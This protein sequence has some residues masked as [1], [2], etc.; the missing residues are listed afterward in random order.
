MNLGNIFVIGE[1]KQ[2][3]G[4]SN[5]IFIFD[6]IQ[7]LKLT[8]RR[9]KDIV[10]SFVDL[11]YHP[12]NNNYAILCSPN[13]REF[14]SVIGNKIDKWMVKSIRF[15]DLV[16]GSPLKKAVEGYKGRFKQ[17]DDLVIPL[18]QILILGEDTEK[19]LTLDYVPEA[20]TKKDIIDI[21]G[22]KIVQENVRELSEEL[23][24]KKETKYPV[25]VG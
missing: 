1:L 24:D 13:L 9:Y 23:S 19:I 11:I 6:E 10:D 14:N 25:G 2:A 21:L 15:S 4:K 20:D 5:G 7:K 8:D 12:E 22:G 17:L 16:H 18:N 3:V